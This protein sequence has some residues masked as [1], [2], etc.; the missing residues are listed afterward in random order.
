MIRKYIENITFKK[1]DF[2]LERLQGTDYENCCFENC[3][4]E[5]QDLSGV[6]FLECEF[7]GCNL[8]NAKLI[9][10]AFQNVKFC[11]CKMLGLHFNDCNAFLFAVSFENCHLNF[12]VFYNVKLLKTKIV[13]SEF[14]EVDFTRADLS[15]SIFDNCNLSGSVFEG[16]NL[17]NVDFRTAYNYTF[18]PEKNRMK[19]S[20][21][22]M[23]GI[24]GLLGKYDISIE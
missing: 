7:D 14:L 2:S 23:S 24:G 3:N 8:S 19:K 16:T 15:G 9:K 22:S 21:F 13:R 17:M 12:S 4:F 1:T 5:G 6:N 18:D 20:K 11:N 10:T